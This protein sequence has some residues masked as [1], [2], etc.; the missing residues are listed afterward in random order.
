MAAPASTMMPCLRIASPLTF[1]LLQ[2]SLPSIPSLSGR[3]EPLIAE[4]DQLHGHHPSFQLHI[5][6]MQRWLAIH[7]GYG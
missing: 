3:E 6:A 4:R 2:F 1:H 5:N 7:N